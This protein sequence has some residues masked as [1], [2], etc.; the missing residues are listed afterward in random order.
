MGE[1]KARDDTISNLSKQLETT[2]E[3]KE[4]YLTELLSFKMKMAE[5][6][7]MDSEMHS[8]NQ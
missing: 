1:K 3:E 2:R 8:K 4:R 5:E 7:D 6:F